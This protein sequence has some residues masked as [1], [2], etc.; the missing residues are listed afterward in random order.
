[1]RFSNNRNRKVRA[2]AEDIITGVTG[3]GSTT[4]FQP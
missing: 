1:M 3:I 2:V 4:H